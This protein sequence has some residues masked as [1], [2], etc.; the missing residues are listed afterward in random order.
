MNGKDIIN[1]LGELDE[2][3]L[4]VNVKKPRK[5]AMTPARWIAA[6]AALLIVC[7]SVTAGAVAAS[8][9]RF[10]FLRNGSNGYSADFEL[11]KYKWSEFKGGIT[12]APEIIRRQ[13]ASFTPQPAWSSLSVPPGRFGR[14]FDSQ[15]EAVDYVGLTALKTTYFPYESTEWFV[16]VTG[17]G[18]GRISEAELFA[19]IILSDENDMGAS[20]FV[21]ILTEH[22][23][24]N[25]VS[26]GGDWGDHDPGSMD[27]EEFTASSGRLCQYA[28]VG[29]P[30]MEYQCVTGY[31]VE[32]GIL[33]SLHLNF[34]AGG[35]DR[36][37]E[38][39]HR[40]A[41]SF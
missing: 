39:L 9:G 34:R 2:E 14:R 15:R 18:E 40:W 11:N 20:A 29:V 38:E 36:A 6:A 28:K 3:L 1:G 13:Y 30:D 33:Y 31:I 10:D 17:D 25:N 26:N 41:D 21:T 16:G 8:K 32:D 4:E 7:G 24:K 5:R 12:E 22:S 37:M 35:L 19:Q 23:E 27:F